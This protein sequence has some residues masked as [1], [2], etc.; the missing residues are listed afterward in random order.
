LVVPSATPSLDHL[1]DA[2][3]ETQH[4]FGP[5]AIG[6][7]GA[8]MLGGPALDDATRRDKTK[9]EGNDLLMTIIEND[10]RP[11]EGAP[12]DDMI[13]GFDGRAATLRSSQPLSHGVQ[14]DLTRCLSRARRPDRCRRTR[15]IST[16]DRPGAAAPGIQR[17]SDS[18]RR[19]SG[20]ASGDPMKRTFLWNVVRAEQRLRFR[21]TMPAAGAILAALVLVAP[22]MAAASEPVLIP[23]SG[24]ALRHVYGALSVA[25]QKYANEQPASTNPLLD[26]TGRNCAVGQR[27]PVFFLVG[28][29]GSATKTRDCT[30]PAS[31]FLFFPM[32]NCNWIHIP[33][34]IPVVGDDKTSVDQVWRALQSPSEGCG[35]RDNATKLHATV[36]HVAIVDPRANRDRF[37]VCAGPATEGCTAP[38]FS[39]TFPD[40]NLYRAIGVP[41]PGGTYFPAVADGYYILLA[42]LSPGVHTL[43]FG[44]SAG[45]G[46][47][48]FSQKITYTLRV[49]AEPDSD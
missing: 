2:I 14:G 42:P 10:S 43:N 24:P 46:G 29:F 19:R 49:E 48:A 41:L 37:Y 7:D 44:G 16:R 35:P 13:A 20:G 36:D 6:T 39:L 12:T 38:A 25:W 1:I 11:A 23:N 5:T 18:A 28:G 9:Y 17:T 8:E 31:K 21:A 4:E 45:V 32:V 3:R 47:N 30:V 33:A 26:G 22:V 27:G 34:N 40:N 15:C